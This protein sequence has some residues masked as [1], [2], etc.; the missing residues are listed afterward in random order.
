ME[1][2]L[3]LIASIMVFSALFGVGF[4]IYGETIP[5]IIAT[6]ITIAGGVLVYKGWK[7]MR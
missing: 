1:I 7:K 4:W 5:A 6:A 2:G 3:M